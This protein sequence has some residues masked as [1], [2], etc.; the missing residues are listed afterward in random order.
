MLDISLNRIERLFFGAT[1][2]FTLSAV[3]ASLAAALLMF[4]LGLQSTIEAFAQQFFPPVQGADALPPD[5]STVISLMVALD[6]FLLGLVL[7]FFG[8]GVY[9]LFVR[10]HFSSRDLGLPEWLHVDQIGQLKQTLAEVIIVVLFVLFL[11]IALQTFHGDGLE[12]SPVGIARFLV[13]PVAILLL[14]GALRLV[15]LHPKPRSLSE[16]RQSAAAQGEEQ[17][18]SISGAPRR[19]PDQEEPAAGAGSGD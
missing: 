2:L 12:L 16:M 4:Y 9:G 11:R 6:R 3:L 10:P 7:L 8:Y 18:L 17:D 5:E 15:A 19:P 1:R 13:L 14:A